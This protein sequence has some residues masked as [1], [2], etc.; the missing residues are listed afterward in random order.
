[1][2]FRAMDCRRFLLVRSA[3]PAGAAVGRGTSD[4]MSS[5][6]TRVRG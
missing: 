4:L 5:R 2:M 3:G 1:V 6:P